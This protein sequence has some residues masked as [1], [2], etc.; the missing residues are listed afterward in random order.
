M[1]LGCAH[2]GNNPITDRYTNPH[3]KE[4]SILQLHKNV[5]SVFGEGPKITHTMVIDNVQS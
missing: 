1:Q 2:V 4:D 3:L 5:G